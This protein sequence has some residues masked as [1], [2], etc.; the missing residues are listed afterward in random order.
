M[1]VKA[2]Y[3]NVPVQ[4]DLLYTH[5]YARQFWNIQKNKNINEIGITSKVTTTCVQ[6]SHSK[7]TCFTT[8]ESFCTFRDPG[9]GV[10]LF[11]RTIFLRGW[12]KFWNR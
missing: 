12:E 1:Q 10:W 5:K 11:L 8:G 7:N 3:T 6:L 4:H 9:L 2:K